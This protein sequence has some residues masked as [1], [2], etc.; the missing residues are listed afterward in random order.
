MN[1]KLIAVIL[2][3]ILMI[4]SI[5]CAE[6]KRGERP[7]IDIYQVPDSAMEQGRIR[8]KLHENFTHLTQSSRT[9]SGQLKRSGESRWD[10]LNTMAG[11]QKV[12]LLFDS[13]ALNTRHA[14][15]HREWGFDRWLELELDS[16]AN[17]R[18]IVMEYRKLSD[19]VE[20]AEPEYKKVRYR[21]TETT[22]Y[23]GYA[24][25][26]RWSGNDP[27]LNEQWHYNNT[28]QQS[29]TIGKDIKLFDA[30][31]IERGHEDI[32]VAIIDGGIQTNHPDISHNMWSGLGYNF[33]TNSSALTAD[34]HGTHVA[35]TVAAVNN[36]GIGVAGVAGGSYPTRGVSLMSCQVF[37]DT[38]GGGFH[39]APIYAAD[40]GAAISQNS[41]GYQNVGV[42]NQ[43]DLDAIDYFNT[44]GG[45]NI[46]SGGLTIF[47]A[48]N[49]NSGGNWY[50]GY[51]SAAMAV[52]ATNNLD[53]RS[54]YSNYGS[55]V[56]ISAP[57]GET[58]YESDPKGVL[59]TVS[60]SGYDFYQGT[61]MACPHVSGVA[62]LVL[63]YAHRNDITLSNTQLRNI[64]KDTADN[65]YPQNPSYT[66]M[67]GTGRVNAYAALSSLDPSQPSVS[68]TAPA[69][70]SVHL[71][72]NNV[73]VT[74]TATDGD[75]S[76]SSVAFYKND[77]L[78]YTD[79]SSP[80]AWT[81]DTDTESAGAY[82][83]KAI[84][85][86][87]DSNT[88]ESSISL[89]LVE[90]ATEAI[91]GSGNDT[92]GTSVASPINVYYKSLHGQSVYT[93]EELNA[94]G[95]FGP[96]SITQIGFNIVSLPIYN[97]P[98]FIVRMKHTTD[99][100][101]ASWINNTGMQ[102]VYSVSSY[103]PQVG[104]DMLTLSTPFNWN[105]ED[106]LV[107][108]T[109]FS[110]LADWNSSGTVKTSSISSGYRYAR[111]DAAD[112]TN[113]FSG[114][115][116]AAYRPNLKIIVQSP[117]ADPE[118]QV[119]PESKDFGLIASGSSASETFT[120]TNIGGSDLTVNSIALSNADPAFSLIDSNSYPIDIPGGSNIQVGVTF[121]PTSAGAFSATLVITDAL[122][123]K[124]IHEVTINGSAYEP[125]TVPFVEGFEA[126]NGNWMIINGT[127]VNK[128]HIAEAAAHTGS[129]SIYI[130]DDGGISNSY[131]I[132]TSSVTHFYADIT[133]PETEDDFYLR[134]NWLANG[135]D[136]T[137]LNYDYL[138]VYLVDTSVTP[139][140]GTM[141]SSGALFG[142]D[143]LNAGT[144]QNA[145][146]QLPDGLS[147]T[148][149]RLVFT[150]RNDSSL[151]TQPP[152]AIDNI[153]IVSQ[154]SQ[155]IALII[156]GESQID[157]P[158]VSDP[159][160]NVINPSVLIDGV[161]GTAVSYR[162]GYTSVTSPFANAGLDITLIADGFSGA[163][164]IIDHNLGFI[165][166]TI[167]YSLDGEHWSV[168]TASPAWTETNLDFSVSGTK[169]RAQDLTIVFSNSSEGT[170]PITL[171]SFTA[172]YSANGYVRV[173]WAT[174]SETAVMGYYILR[175]VNDNLTEA[176]AVS[177][178]IEA[179]NASDGA[180]YSFRDSDLQADTVY[181]Y[182]LN[183][184]DFNGSEGF[185]GPLQVFVENNGQ[186]SEPVIPTITQALGN[187]PNPFNPS[188]NLRYSLAEAADVKI[189]IY[190]NRGQQVREY[191]VQ[192]S[193]PGFFTL[194][195]D[196]KDASGRDL[197][198]GVYFYRMQI[199]QYSAT[200]RMLLLK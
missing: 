138:Q 61:S 185:Y 30:W 104:W 92:T 118:F 172:S 81:W 174:A 18:D 63:S 69:N 44:N 40:N 132:D 121:A 128:W 159:F 188:T 192:H 72:G 108:D 47:A 94:A 24:A 179:A 133:F 41:W 9:Q 136:G 161:A 154:A 31:N 165:P 145:D 66:G 38:S 22:D 80:Y 50:P 11:V 116:V 43:G 78:Q 26:G 97:L 93:K 4:S 111:S 27:R 183:N 120:I 158:A 13:P 162:V 125:L 102:T 52:A 143:L 177:P 169:D 19:I 64:L 36:N 76:I 157:L 166:P 10:A 178:L 86:D 160:S 70:G 53:I 99:V 122:G 195:F 197:S 84:A 167:A 148:T 98:N 164:L 17:I 106:N 139:V 88:A 23:L 130:S 101:V 5:L 151:G 55:W 14:D 6:V 186:G 110:L 182:W 96:I 126:D 37:N 193:K 90:P 28:G 34:D 79:Y 74:A 141:L 109:A 176:Q 3:A 25:A 48:G 137:T 200:N 56:E 117:E 60:G 147:G 142:E 77:V 32:I 1:Q 103:A 115:L 68:I 129:K 131:T 175:S 59:S 153:R 198:S 83:I 180:T 67:L 189:R 29:G 149:K 58:F 16:R 112:Q 119:S 42:F 113:V 20:I 105:G 123:S 87:N 173:D 135:E 181:Y 146:I 168:V 107:V 8:I 54:Y 155:D 7:F 15:R 191:D 95:I 62:A 71:I 57:G 35:G 187:Y 194:V 114:T 150:W 51:Y 12:N 134:F 75:G 100:N 46:L 199:G 170:L 124:T 144:W 89:S 171:S 82:S 184:Q 33:V 91:L 196:G 140:A 73:E 156:D 127:Q 2:I 65:H 45:G 39:L 85:T 152:A 163:Y 49:N 190:N 21:N